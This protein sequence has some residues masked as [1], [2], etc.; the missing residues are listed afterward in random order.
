[1]RRAPPPVSRHAIM[2]RSPPAADRRIIG[3]GASAPAAVDAVEDVLD[4]QQDGENAGAEQAEPEDIARIRREGLAMKRPASAA[5]VNSGMTKA[6]PR[7]SSTRTRLGRSSGA[8]S[9]RRLTSMTARMNAAA[10][11]ISPDW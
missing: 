9:S 11:S 1:M 2:S 7:I 4:L 10:A 3:G 8:P 5:I 6:R